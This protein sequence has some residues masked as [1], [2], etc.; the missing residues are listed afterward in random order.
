MFNWVCPRCG[1]DVP[2]S[3]T[4]CPFCAD[5]AAA[6]QQL[7]PQQYAPPPQQ[8][9]PAAPAWAP[10]PQAPPPQAVAQQQYAPP[11]A[12][13]A[14]PQQQYAPPAPAWAPPPQRQ[15]LPTW[16]LS[17]AFGLAFVGI[18]AAIYL[19]LNHQPSTASATAATSAATTA[20]AS[21]NPLQKYI[22]VTGVRLVTENKKPTAHFVVVNHSGAEMAGVTGK[23]TLLAGDSRANATPVGT[24]SFTVRSLAAGG[25]ADLSAPF[26]TGMKPY[27]LPD[28]QATFAQ[29]EVTSPAP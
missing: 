18:F 6:A 23:V 19:S 27:E 16:L 1:K 24:F 29:V 11:P 15:G 9:A 4:E 14:P 3:K 5:T 22:E 10:P 26:E 17:V 2:P 7:P 20:P 21:T 8:Y 28:W 12:Q 25:S 13:Y